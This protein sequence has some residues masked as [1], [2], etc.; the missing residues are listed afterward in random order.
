[1][2]SA[3]QRV[4]FLRRLPARTVLPSRQ[5][6]P[7]PKPIQQQRTF[8][9]I[10]KAGQVCDL[11]ESLAGVEQFTAQHRTGAILYYT[12]RWC[13]PCQKIKPY[14]ETLATDHPAVALGLI[15]VDENPEAAAAANISSIPTFVAYVNNG[16]TQRFS[17][18]D[19]QQLQQLVQTLDNAI[20]PS[21]TS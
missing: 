10:A 13:P 9:A 3:S 2:L 17:G 12:A 21:K 6:L 16:V 8:S 11:N 7:P 15:D 1:M 14:Y 4:L 18:A 5:P 19:V 20:V